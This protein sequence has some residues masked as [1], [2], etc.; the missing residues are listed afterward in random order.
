MDDLNGKGLQAAGASEVKR[1]SNKTKS[2]RLH[3]QLSS[4]ARRVR[5][6][7]SLLRL[8]RN[9]IVCLAKITKYA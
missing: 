9:G 6:K 4:K 2:R 3:T 1:T 8:T 5:E 7:Q